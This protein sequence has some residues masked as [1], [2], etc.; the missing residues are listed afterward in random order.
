MARD[1][2]GLNGD[3]RTPTLTTGDIA[4]G[5]NAVNRAVGLHPHRQRVAV[6]IASSGLLAISIT[7]HTAHR[8]QPHPAPWA[9]PT[10]LLSASKR[11]RPKRLARYKA[12]SARRIKLVADSPAR[13]C[14]KPAEKV[15]MGMTMPLYR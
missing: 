2:V 10:L 1:V 12:L 3:G 15:G 8:P 5:H 13:Y 9:I 14:A 6:G 7:A 4:V 11:L